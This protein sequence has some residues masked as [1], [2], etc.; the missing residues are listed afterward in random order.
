MPRG[1]RH[2]LTG[3]LDWTERGHILRVDGG[4]VWTLD[5]DRALRKWLGKRVTI[6]GVRTGFDFLSVER[7]TAAGGT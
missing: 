4:G 2:T 7:I 3:L 1:T 6:E 5:P